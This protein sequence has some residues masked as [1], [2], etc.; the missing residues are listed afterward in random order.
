MKSKFIHLEGT[1]L[2]GKTSV[3]KRLLSKMPLLYQHNNISSHGPEGLGSELDKM[4]ELDLYSRTTLSLGYAACVLA[5]I[6]RF[7]WPCRDTIQDSSSS[8]RCLSRLAIDGQDAL[9]DIVRSI[10]ELDHPRFTR[11]YYL[12]TTID[13]RIKRANSMIGL[14]RN[15]L[16]ILHDTEKFVAMD[17]VALSISGELFNSTVIDTTNTSPDEIVNIIE[18]DINGQ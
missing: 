13:E 6:D 15:D 18:Q 10:V 8:I 3:A 11:S 17:K 12:T 9:F 1:D 2:S 5:D 16:M 4:D 7:E 14:T